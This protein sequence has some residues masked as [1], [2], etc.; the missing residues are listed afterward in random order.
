MRVYCN[1]CRYYYY[2]RLSP[3]KFGP[4]KC[5]YIKN[6]KDDPIYKNNIY[7]K[8]ADQINKNNNCSWYKRKWRLFWIK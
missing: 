7:I 1:D 2:C 4:H 8:C 3:L 5:D 6:L